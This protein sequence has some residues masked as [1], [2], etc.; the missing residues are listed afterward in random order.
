LRYIVNKHRLA[1]YIKEIVKTYGGIH[2]LCHLLSINSLN[3]VLSQESGS[4]PFVEVRY[5]DGVRKM[6]MREFLISRLRQKVVETEG[7]RTPLRPKASTAI[8]NTQAH[9]PPVFTHNKVFLCSEYLNGKDE[10]KDYD[11]GD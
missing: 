1:E 6:N 5:E 8:S 4:F 7:V 3:Y 11:N 9:V 2:P 10:V